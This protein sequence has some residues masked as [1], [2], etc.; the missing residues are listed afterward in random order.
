VVTLFLQTVDIA[1]FREETGKPLETIS[2]LR[3]VDQHQ[4]KPGFRQPAQI[5]PTSEAVREAV[6]ERISVG[7]V[8]EELPVKRMV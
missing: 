3:N 4:I 1:A 2:A 5:F 6:N 8:G 7:F